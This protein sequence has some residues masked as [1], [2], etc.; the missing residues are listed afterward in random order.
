M[1][2]LAVTKMKVT[3]QPFRAAIPEIPAVMDNTVD[4]PVEITPAVPAVP[5]QPL[6][7]H[8]EI[9]NVYVERDAAL[10]AQHLAADARG[11][12]PGIEYYHISFNGA[13][14][15]ASLQPVNLK[16]GPRT[17]AP[18]REIVEIEAGGQDLGSAIVEV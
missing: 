6:I 16:A 2:F 12:G 1:S 13:Q 7:E 11:D 4:P 8:D 17:Q 15:Q 10:V 9:N 3:D 5:E 14:L 18:A